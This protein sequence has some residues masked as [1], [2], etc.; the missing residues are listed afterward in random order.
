MIVRK[1][2]GKYIMTHIVGCILHYDAYYQV[3]RIH[4]YPDN[5]LNNF[6][7]YPDN[8]FNNFNN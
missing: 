8:R 7:S 2:E 4:T 6:N 5:R 1:E 3:I